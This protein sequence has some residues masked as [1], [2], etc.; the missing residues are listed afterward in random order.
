MVMDPR[1]S[2]LGMW[3][4]LSD[5]RARPVERMTAV[6]GLQQGGGGMGGMGGMSRPTPQQQDEVTIDI[7]GALGGGARAA[8]GLGFEEEESY[9]G[10]SSGADD[11]HPALV[12]MA[13]GMMQ[14]D[15]TPED[16]G[17][18]IASMGFGIAAGQ[19]PNALTNIGAGGAQGIE[20]LMRL[21]Q[22]R[23]LQ[24]MREAQMIQ[25]EDLKRA[26]IEE[27]R[28]AAIERAQVQRESIM[29]REEAARAATEQRE[30]DSKRDALTAQGLADARAQATEVSR[31]AAEDRAAALA[32]TRYNQAASSRL[33]DY[34][35]TGVW[36]PIDG[37]E[38]HNVSGPPE[39]STYVG[40]NV[41]N[42]GL[43]LAARN[44]LKLAQPQITLATKTV[45]KALDNTIELARELKNHPGRAA[46][47]GLPGPSS[48]IPGTDAWDF[49]TKLDVMKNRQFVGT[50]QAIRDASPTGGAVGNVS[51]REGNRFEGTEAALTRWQSEDAFNKGMD[52]L[53]DQ[54]TFSRGVFK[55]K[56][57]EDFGDLP[58]DEDPAEK[59]PGT[60]D[61]MKTGVKEPEAPPMTLE[62]LRA[63]ARGGR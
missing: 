3:G 26:Q 51:D 7:M 1:M 21:R 9:G 50:L 45:I 6:A 32:E 53:I 19:S 14:D 5:P 31:V 8:D 40:P 41:K 54:A 60:N 57:E 44:K 12:Q 46:A 43:P 38:S 18:G 20:S 4:L 63:W 17:L 24:R 13:R 36:R 22:A 34:N 29:Q 49:L 15:L 2:G 23:A 48:A 33:K 52:H 59:P 35:A 25:A 42:P 37:D 30:A 11:L 55:S 10:L 16:K 58:P 27:A 28:R 62:Q 39:E 47:V 56:Y 61:G